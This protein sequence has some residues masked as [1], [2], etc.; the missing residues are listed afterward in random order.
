MKKNILVIIS[1]V[2]GIFAGGYI[3][4]N[5]SRNVLIP[6]REQSDKITQYYKLLDKWLRMRQS[7][8]MLNCYFEKKGYKKI[9]IYGMKELGR[10]LVDELRETEVEIVCVIDQN[11]K[12]M[13]SEVKVITPEEKIP[14]VEAVVV[15]AVYY[16]QEIDEKLSTKVDCPILSLEEVLYE[17]QDLM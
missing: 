6:M 12:E 11:T 2:I 7:G 17:V 16:F 10:R 8:I 3:V 14:D 4:G 9:A 5:V 1:A 15:T 13:H